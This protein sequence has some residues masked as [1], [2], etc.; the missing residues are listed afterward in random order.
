MYKPAKN[1]LDTIASLVIVKTRSGWVFFKKLKPTAIANGF[2]HGKLAVGGVHYH[3]Y[4]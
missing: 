2:G 1:S 4:I 3:P